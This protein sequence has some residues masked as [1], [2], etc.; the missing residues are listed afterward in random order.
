MPEGLRH[1]PHRHS[2]R[3]QAAGLGG[4]DS[5]DFASLAFLSFNIA[6]CFEGDEGAFFRVSNRIDDSG[7]QGSK[8]PAIECSE[9]LS[10]QKRLQLTGFDRLCWMAV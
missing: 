9:I 5:A 1:R 7:L 6:G 10:S 8:K 4:C 3:L 2:N